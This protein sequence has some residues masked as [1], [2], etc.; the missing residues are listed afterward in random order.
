[1]T[2]GNTLPPP[3]DRPTMAELAGRDPGGG[4]VR[5]CPACNRRLFYV[6]STWN[7]ANGTIR[8]LRK[9][10]ICGHAVNS[11]EVFDE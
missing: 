2:E 8:R 6:V 10:S 7:L 4:K 5:R 1:M 9:C 3:Q 11:S